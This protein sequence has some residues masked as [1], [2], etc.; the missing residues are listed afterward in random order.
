M[1]MLPQP[2]P[3]F[4]HGVHHSPNRLGAARLPHP[5]LYR[6]L[7]TSLPLFATMLLI[8]T[9]YLFHLHHA[10]QHPEDDSSNLDKLGRDEDVGGNSPGRSAMRHKMG[11]A[12]FLLKKYEQQRKTEKGGMREA[13][14]DGWKGG[15]EENFI[16]MVKEAQ[17]GALAAVSTTPA[18]KATNTTTTTDGRHYPDT[19]KSGETRNK[20]KGGLASRLSGNFTKTKEPIELGSW[21]RGD[22]ETL[23]YEAQHAASLAATTPTATS[24][25]ATTT[26]D[27]HYDYE[28][29][30]N[31]AEDEYV[32]ALPKLSWQQLQRA[33]LE[34]DLLPL[35]IPPT[36]TARGFSGLPYARTP[37]LEGARRGA[38]T[39]PD[40]DPRVGRVLSS[41]LAFWNEP[42]GTRDRDAGTP[43][44]G[45]HP[46]VPPPLAEAALPPWLPGRV[47]RRRYLTFEPDTGG[48]NNLR[49]SFENVLVLAAAT[50]RTLVLPPDQLMYLLEARKGSRRER[51]YYQLVNITT[52]L[53]RR[54][55]LISAQ[56]F[57]KLE[58]GKDGLV[59]LTQYNNTWQEHLMQITTTC[60]ERR[61]SDV[62]C[63]DLY[64]H[65]RDHGELATVT[66]DGPHENCFVFDADVFRYGEDHISR[67][68]PSVKSRIKNFCWQRTP[69]YYSLTEHSAPLWHF[70]TMSEEYRLLAHSYAFLFFT[71]PKVGNYYK[72]FVRDFVKFHDSVYC[73]AGKIILALQHESYLHNKVLSP[74][75]NNTSSLSFDHELVGGYSSMHIRRGDLQFKEVK[76]DSAQWYQNTKE[77]WKP[78]EVLYV[79]T[80]ESDPTWFDGFRTQHSGPL[81]FFGHYKDL[82]DL[83]NI[84]PTLYGLIETVVA[85][86]G[87][88]FAGT[89][90][91]T[92]SG[93][94]IR[95][96]GYYGMSMYYTY[97]SYLE[98]KYFMHT[99][100]NVGDASYYAGEYPVGWKNIDGDEFVDIAIEFDK[101][102]F[103][104][105]FS[106]NFLKDESAHF[107]RYLMDRYKA[108]ASITFVDITHT[109]A[110]HEKNQTQH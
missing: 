97:Y 43:A 68:S 25:N 57:L 7:S 24:T 47:P 17:Q 46:F 28:N 33:L 103:H 85:S 40:T 73:A 35:P 99:W 104:E 44:T 75:E 101:Q 12:R 8:T 56:E 69:V 63:E 45:P 108:A 72:R 92:F 37:A 18:K 23:A 50:G 49:I 98:R 79:A 38:I 55:P 4:P 93:Y 48:W 107:P 106:V 94:I 6:V 34:K 100:M 22:E 87:S 20:A 82:A 13:I 51:N 15:D 91:S 89:W 5:L 9:L 88:V 58:G 86:R 36:R 21:K 10:H 30:M 62:Y 95:L 53:L 102:Q 77:I 11:L 64:D 32:T 59:S 81:R 78:N 71:D 52:D 39:C 96:R 60:E 1:T 74:E 83:D 29:E 90:F 14:E 54:V 42:R 3:R 16:K 41:M 80:D 66:T 70:E 19:D 105:Q 109:G 76:F 110:G 31:D 26:G 27:Y 61:L 84:D 67:L 2:T 65:Y